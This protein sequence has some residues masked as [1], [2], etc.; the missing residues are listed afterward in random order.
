M[1]AACL[2][3]AAPVAVLCYMIAWRTPGSTGTL[4]GFG[5][6]ATIGIVSAALYIGP[7]AAVLMWPYRAWRVV[8]IL[9]LLGTMISAQHWIQRVIIESEGK[10]SPPPGI[11]FILLIL[12]AIGGVLA[13]FG[14]F[15]RRGDARVSLPPSVCRFCGHDALTDGDEACPECRNARTVAKKPVRT[16]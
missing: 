2:L 4:T 15:A 6:A 9:V 10:Q 3:W 13:L 16:V 1:Y 12:A 7:L 11:G 5:V 14:S 8:L